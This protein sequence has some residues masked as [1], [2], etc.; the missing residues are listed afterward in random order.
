MVEALSVFEQTCSNQFFKNSS[1]ILF[2]NK[3][4]LLKTKLEAGVLFSTSFPE[5]KGTLF[6]YMP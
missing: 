2:F 1:I 4:D 5:Y 6:L 3:I